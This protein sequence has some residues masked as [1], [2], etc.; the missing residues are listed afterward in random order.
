MDLTVFSLH[1]FF[2]VYYEHSDKSSAALQDILEARRFLAWIS[3]FHIYAEVE[4][5]VTNQEHP[6][7][8]VL[9]LNI[10]CWSQDQHAYTTPVHKLE[11]LCL[12]NLNHKHLNILQFNLAMHIYLSQIYQLSHFHLLI[13]S[14]WDSHSKFLLHTLSL[15]TPLITCNA[16]NGLNL[17]HFSTYSE[18][19]MS[20]LIKWSK[21]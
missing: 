18:L 10:F 1:F 12:S 5:G 6:P 7:P 2:N 13:S 14:F 11:I 16:I 15:E 4:A 9:L 20:E 3:L 19:Y 8:D 17:A 21:S